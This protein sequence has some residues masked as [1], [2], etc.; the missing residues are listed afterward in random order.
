MER[1][2]NLTISF[3]LWWYGE[4]LVL[5]FVF[6]KRWLEYLADLFSVEVCL[7]TLFAPWKRDQ[8]SYENLSLQQRFQV[9]LMNLASRLVGMMVK[10]FVLLAFAAVETIALICYLILVIVWL[11]WPILAVWAIMHGFILLRGGSGA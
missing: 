2:G 5:L 9:L 8:I 3:V 4:A 11:V 6:L 1:S 10:L 7:K